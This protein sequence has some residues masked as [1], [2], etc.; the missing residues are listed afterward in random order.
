MIETE[1]RETSGATPRYAKRYPLGRRQTQT[2]VPSSRGTRPTDWLGNAHQ[3][4]GQGRQGR[5]IRRIF[6][7]IWYNS[8]AFSIPVCTVGY[9]F[10]SSDHFFNSSKNTIAVLPKSVIS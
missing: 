10:C 5:L 7:V 4:R 8:A 2:P 1:T 9:I 3:E 6:R